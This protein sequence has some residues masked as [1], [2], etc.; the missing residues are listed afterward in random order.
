V[1]LLPITFIAPLG[2]LG[3]VHGTTAGNPIPG[4]DGAPAVVVSATKGVLKTG[5]GT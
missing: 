4:Q 1:P 2:G 3:G 5:K